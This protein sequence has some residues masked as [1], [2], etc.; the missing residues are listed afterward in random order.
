MVWERNIPYMGQ[1]RK[2]KIILSIT[3][4]HPSQR[5]ARQ[6]IGIGTGHRSIYGGFIT[7]CMDWNDGTQKEGNLIFSGVHIGFFTRPPA[8]GLMMVL[9]QAASLFLDGERRRDYR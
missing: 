1:R 5:M 8:F 7:G 2:A 3:T 9:R 4:T 6:F